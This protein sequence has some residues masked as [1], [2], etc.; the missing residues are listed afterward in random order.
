MR[1]DPE[2]V[3]SPGEAGNKVRN[4]REVLE[5][6]GFRATGENLFRK[7]VQEVL[8]DR[9][10]QEPRGAL[11]AVADCLSPLH[12]ERADHPTVDLPVVDGKEEVAGSDADHHRVHLGR[13]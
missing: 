7:H 10:T 9:R 12:E 13:R 1:R 8:H 6:E 4:R 3:L 2:V 5:V 11:Q